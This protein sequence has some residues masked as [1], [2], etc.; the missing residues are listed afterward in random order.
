MDRMVERTIHTARARLSALDAQLNSLSPLAVLD[1]GYALVLNGEGGLIRSVTQLG[2]GDEVQTRL[3]DGSF[4][5]RVESKRHK[6][7]ERKNEEV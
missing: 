4:R 5:S 3:G 7:Q 2:L 6:I 1:R